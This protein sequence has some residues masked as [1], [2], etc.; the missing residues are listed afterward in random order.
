MIKL[1]RVLFS[2]LYFYNNIISDQY[3]DI[4]NWVRTIER[5]IAVRETEQSRVL[6]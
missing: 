5:F 4:V 2:T 6:T 1:Y 3:N